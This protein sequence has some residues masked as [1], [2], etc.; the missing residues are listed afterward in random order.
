MLHWAEQRALLSGDIVQV[1]PDRRYVSFMYSYPNLIP[2][3]PSKVQHIGDALAPYPFDTIY[4][5][6]FGPRDRAR[7]LSRRPAVGRPL[8]P[9]RHGA[10]AA[11]VVRRQS[12][13]AFGSRKPIEMAGSAG[14][15]LRFSQTVKA[16]VAPSAATSVTQVQ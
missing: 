14:R 1:I 3:P 16:I 13:S 10:G 8:P 15:P 6:W 7:R 4:G 2:L 12:R 11:V 5:A 9:R